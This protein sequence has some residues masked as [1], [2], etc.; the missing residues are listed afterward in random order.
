MRAIYQYVKGEMKDPPQFRIV[1]FAAVRVNYER[2]FI[3]FPT[4]IDPS[5]EVFDVAGTEA[6]D[7][8][9]Y[10]LFRINVPTFSGHFLKAFSVRY[11]LVVLKINTK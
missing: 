9:G 11:G 7:A 6:V 4:P 2:Y 8:D 10:Q 5:N 1:L 3:V